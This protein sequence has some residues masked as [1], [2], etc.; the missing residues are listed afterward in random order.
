MKNHSISAMISAIIVFYIIEKE[1]IDMESIDDY[2]S[3][4]ITNMES[5]YRFTS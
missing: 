1:S 3:S 2:T 5:I 4:H